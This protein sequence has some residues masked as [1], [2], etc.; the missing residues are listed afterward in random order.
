MDRRS[1]VATLVLFSLLFLTSCTAISTDVVPDSPGGLQPSAVLEITGAGIEITL[2]AEEMVN[3]TQ[4][5]LTCNHISSSGEVFEATISGFSLS[6]LL[7]ENGFS[8]E[9][10]GSIN[11]FAS[12]GYVMSAPA[13]TYADS[14]VYIML[15]RDGENLAYPRSCIPEQ[16]SMY[17]VKNLTKIELIPYQ[18]TLAREQAKITRISFFR[19]AVNDL[20]SVQLNNRG[21]KVAAYSL[22]AYFEKY[23][24]EV[25]AETVALIAR[26]GHKKTEAAEIFL[27]N[28][29]TLEPEP[30]REEDP[31]LYFSEEMSLGMRVK[32]LEAVI[33]P[34]DAVYFGSEISIPDLFQLTGMETAEN[35]RF[36][37]S[38]G[39]ITEIPAAAIPFGTIYPDEKRGYIR[40]KFDGYDFS[41]ITGGGKVKYLLMIET[42]H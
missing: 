19:E 35:Y 30:G 21:E 23:G 11:F 27:A 8:L 29:V 41:G 13:E 36:I 5:T 20:E 28:Y 22:R 26:D 12:D 10:I 14:D 4:K 25:P 17:W 1:L 2:T 38:D 31:P 3:R 18:T 15:S 24:H 37:A 34:P 6:E 16:R 42:V 32:Q 9:Q 7:G 33:A 39:Y 40:A